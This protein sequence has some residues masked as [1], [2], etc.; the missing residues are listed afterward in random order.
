MPRGGL[1]LSEP[2][3]R[4]GRLAGGGGKKGGGNERREERRG[5]GQ[6]IK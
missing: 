4:R 6:D 5:Y 2:M 1:P 3:Q